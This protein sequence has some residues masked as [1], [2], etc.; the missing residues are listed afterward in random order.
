MAMQ[1]KTL[2]WRNFNIFI[3]K[4]KILMFMVITPLMICLML[5]YMSNI[6][7]SLKSVGSGEQPIEPIGK[8][9]KCTNG[10]WIKS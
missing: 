8:V 10:N 7:D 6:V 3:R 9:Q 4:K 5:R 2:L 1:T